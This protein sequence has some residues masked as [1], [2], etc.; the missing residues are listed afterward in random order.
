MTPATIARLKMRMRSMVALQLRLAETARSRP[1]LCT[2]ISAAGCCEAKEKI[3]PSVVS[4][5]H[6]VAAQTLP[7]LGHDP[8]RELVRRG[9]VEMALRAHEVIG[10]VRLD[11]ACERLHQTPRRKI[12]DHQRHGHQC[13]A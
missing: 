2:E 12:V 13:G 9:V 6:S 10:E 1:R 8:L 4:L 5:S 11:S 3:A 7:R